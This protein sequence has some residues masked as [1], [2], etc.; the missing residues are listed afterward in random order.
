[1]KKQYTHVKEEQITYT[2]KDCT[3]TTV[4]I[5]QQPQPSL[6]LSIPSI[7]ELLIQQKLENKRT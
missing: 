3:N 6:Y 2:F 1:M 5:S 4:H 7:Y